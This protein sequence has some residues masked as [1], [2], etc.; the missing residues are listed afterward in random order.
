MAAMEPV[1]EPAVAE[2]SRPV[3]ARTALSLPDRT[4]AEHRSLSKRVAS[5]Q[6]VFQAGASAST[7]NNGQAEDC[8]A[9]N[10][11]VEKLIEALK[12]QKLGLT[13]KPRS[14]PIDL[15][16]SARALE[17]A[18]KEID[19]LTLGGADLVAKA[20]RKRRSLRVK[21]VS[22]RARRSDEEVKW[23]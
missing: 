15:L 9:Q 13:V 20:S 4:W 6:V 7:M 5:Q 10:E 1:S 2:M 21:G 18:F 22:R 12:L 8:A 16:C 19:L 23:A 17:L 11:T 14:S 3:I